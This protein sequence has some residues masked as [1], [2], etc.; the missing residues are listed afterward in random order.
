VLIFSA[1]ITPQGPK[2]QRFQRGSGAQNG[3]AA[4]ENDRLAEPDHAFLTR[5]IPS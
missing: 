5:I 2:F 3:Q 1:E 4:G